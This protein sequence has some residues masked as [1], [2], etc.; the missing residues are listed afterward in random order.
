MGQ[1]VSEI[2]LTKPRIFW[3]LT[4]LNNSC[5]EEILN[6]NYEI[7]LPVEKVNYCNNKQA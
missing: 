6:Q 7:W 4:V 3:L 1:Q 5:K 2:S